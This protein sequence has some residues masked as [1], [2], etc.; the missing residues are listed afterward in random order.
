MNLTTLT[1]LT[2]FDHFDH[3]DVRVKLV[4]HGTPLEYTTKI[5]H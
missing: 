3:F 4:L 2:T 1:N 5:P